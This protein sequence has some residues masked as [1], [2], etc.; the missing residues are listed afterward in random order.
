MACKNLDGLNPEITELIVA[1]ITNDQPMISKSIIS[2]GKVLK[3][4]GELLESIAMIV[5]CD[6]NP[7][8]KDKQSSLG[9]A[10]L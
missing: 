8:K 9:I 6:Y 7:L 3:V 10:E 1:V 5:M 4:D 2:L